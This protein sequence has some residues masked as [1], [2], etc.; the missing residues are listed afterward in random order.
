[1]LVDPLGAALQASVQPAKR[2]ERDGGLE[3]LTALGERLPLLVKLFAAGASQGP[4][5]REGVAQ[6]R[7]EPAIEL[8]TRRD[9]VNGFV[10][11]PKRWIGERTLAWLNRCRRVAKDFAK[12]I[13]SAVAFVHLASMRL[14]V[15]KLCTPSS[16]SWTDSQPFSARGG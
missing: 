8:V 9:Q 11:L 5:F 10:A 4:P 16:T 7:P 6:V 3:L 1:V 2:Q 13:R 14:M 12:R 15:R